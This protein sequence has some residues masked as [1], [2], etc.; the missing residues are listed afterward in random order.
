MNRL[1]AIAAVCAVNA[2]GQTTVAT[3]E[4]TVD[5]PVLLQMGSV[6]DFYPSPSR[7]R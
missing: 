7:P 3:K 1:L 4:G 5:K 6:A 2:L